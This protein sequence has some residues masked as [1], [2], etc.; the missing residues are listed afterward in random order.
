MIGWL[1]ATAGTA[2]LGSV[3]PA[4]NIEL[5]LIGVLSTND[6]LSWWALALAAALGQLV[7]KTLLYFAG[8]GGFALGERFTRMTRVDRIGRWAAWLENFHD[9][10]QRRPWW[11]LG[12]LF[13]SAVVGLP[14]YT[15]MCFATGAAGVP[16]VGFLGVSVLGRSLHF[17][18]VAASPEVIRAL[19]ALFG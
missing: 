4:V 15:I 3:F 13:A 9:R 10:V 19:P 5:Y 7:G 14:P 8:R 17:L 12:A 16:A 11:G 6:R 18:I 1:L 2:A